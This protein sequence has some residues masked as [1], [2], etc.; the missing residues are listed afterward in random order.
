MRIAL[1][2]PYAGATLSAHFPF[3][4]DGAS[5]PAGYPGAPLMTALAKALVERGHR[6]GCISTDYTTPV[7]QLEPFR[8]FH[9]PGVAAYF[10]PQRPHSF[11]S[12][13]GRLGRSLDHFK[14]ERE[15]L[16]AAIKDF[17]PD[18]IHAHWTYEFVW[19]ALDSGV[20]TLATAHDSP[21]KVLRFTPNLYRAARYLMARRVLTRCQHL[22]AVSPDL[23]NDLHNWTDALVSVVPN[24]IPDEVLAAPGCTATA[25]QSK[26]LV[27]VLN[28]WTSL[29]N[30]STALRAFKLAR[31]GNPELQLVCFGSG[32]ESGG[33][34]HRWAA[35]RGLDANVSFR[36]PVPHRVIIEQ[37]RNSTALLHPSR[38]EA[39][40][41]S[42][43]EAM[44]VGLPVI[45][46]R[47]TD[48]VPWQLD[49]GK[50][51]ALVDVTDAEAIAD[52]IAAV[53]TDA[54]Q[55]HRWSETGRA[56]ARRLFSSDAVVDRYV[57]LYAGVRSGRAEHHTPVGAT[58]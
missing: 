45:A 34:A 13:G 39:C 4:T 47:K 44:S 8:V 6:V 30:G 5:L 27:M 37:M 18:L 46:G 55:W 2:G 48:G 29:K 26:T 49:N 16:L 24:P 53:A 15:C 36:G 1:I 38:W 40:C 42:I 56:R 17:A 33:A 20:P 11:R 43:A 28:G 50:A 57:D 23:A 10:C 31:R 21:A 52:G 7:D 41:M 32:F 22:T 3:A 58:P 14:F 35:A 9:A 19:A 25:F 12:A 51:G 54:V